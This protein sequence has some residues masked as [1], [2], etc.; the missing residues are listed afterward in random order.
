MTPVARTGFASGGPKI[1]WSSTLARHSWQAFNVTILVAVAKM[2]LW[3]PR[4]E[5]SEVKKSRTARRARS[6]PNPPGLLPIAVQTRRHKASYG[7]LQPAHH[8]QSCPW[9]HPSLPAARAVKPSPQTTFQPRRRCSGEAPVLSP[10]C[11]KLRRRE[12]CCNLLHQGA[13][14]S[15]VSR[16]TSLSARWAWSSNNTRQKS[17]GKPS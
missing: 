4:P 11:L 6:S 7:N 14:G 3:R 10:I 12:R 2:L 13:Q 15:A 9:S 16:H 5:D 8:P 1:S 17:A